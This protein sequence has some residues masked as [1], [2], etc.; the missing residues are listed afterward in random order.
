MPILIPNTWVWTTS[1]VATTTSATTTIYWL[2]ANSTATTAWYTP[3]TIGTN[4]WPVYWF[5]DDQE[6]QQ[7][8]ERRLETNARWRQR[9]LEVAAPAIIRHR[10]DDTAKQ[11]A[12]EL[13]LEHLTPEQRTMF[14]LQGWFIVWGGRTKTK[15]RIRG[16]RESVVGNVDVMSDDRVTHRLC[17]HCAPDQVPFGDQLLAQKLMI[18]LDEHEFL[19]IANRHP[20]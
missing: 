16:N 14:E 8:V 11:R 17:G 7:R 2:A 4:P 18:E 9:Q 19:R 3:T 5:G 20:A 13:L 15:Y 12:R 1:Q 10:I 6:M